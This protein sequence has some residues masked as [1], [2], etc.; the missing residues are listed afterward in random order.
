MIECNSLFSIKNS[1]VFVL[2]L[3]LSAP[4]PSNSRTPSIILIICLVETYIFKCDCDLAHSRISI[5]MLTMTCLY[6]DYK[7]ACD[8][9]YGSF[10]SSFF[11]FL[12]L[13]IFGEFGF[14]CRLFI[15]PFKISYT[16][17]KK[18]KRSRVVYMQT[19]EGEKKCSLSKSHIYVVDMINSR[20][21]Y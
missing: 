11:P 12:L 18:K 7:C 20:M 17:Q 21:K 2:R 1:F 6:A 3:P 13:L 15:I 19:S 14:N 4:F 16:D 10:S 8:L 5:V 9:L